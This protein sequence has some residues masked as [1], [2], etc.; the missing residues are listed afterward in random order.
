MQR[1]S[2]RILVTHTGSLPR[3]PEM[4]AVFAGER[5]VDAAERAELVRSGVADVVRRQLDAGVDV[6]NDG[7]TGKESYSTYVRERL[8][9]FDGE[10]ESVLSLADLNAYPGARD[11]FMQ[12]TGNDVAEV[13][14]PPACSGPI[15]VADPDAVD[16]DIRNLRAAAEGTGATELF[17]SA[18]SP[19]VIASFFANHHYPN[20]EAYLLALAEAMRHEYEAIAASGIILQ[21]DCPD[22][23]MCRH[24]LFDQ[25]SLEE[26]RS[27]ARLAVEM[28]N[29]ATANIDPDRMRI[30]LCWGNY[31]GPH[32]LDVALADII[33]VVLRARPNGIV[34]EG[35]NPRHEHEWQVFTD[36]E[37]PEGKVLMPGV[38]DSTSNYIEHPELIAQRLTRYADAVG[39][40]N[41][42]AA[43]DCGFATGARMS[44]VDP[45]IAWAKLRAMA[46]GARIASQRLYSRV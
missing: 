14:G 11:K 21:L 6:V 35:A 30:H 18:A 13:L 37:V 36:V 32:H 10:P 44:A 24:V 20:R 34:L 19:G 5:Q 8:T 41:V 7:E 4:R 39:A 46:E 16:A 38:V 25:L 17:L 27:Q 12:V 9:G 22:L 2:E 26:F 43:T 15:A 3:T 42:L 31:E 29:H 33:D 1:S 23:A 40:E 28:I 45:D